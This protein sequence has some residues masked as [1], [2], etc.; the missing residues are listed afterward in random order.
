[1]TQATAV[2]H[3]VVSQKEWLAAR[4]KFLAKE[5]EHMRKG[6]ELAAELRGLPWV[7]VEKTYIFD[8]PT[9]KKSLA[10]LFD[11]RSQL[12][13]DHFMFGPGW[14][15]G[16]PGC[17]FM[18]DH[19]DGMLPHLAN[20]DV[21]YVA[22]SRAT[23]SEIE[24]FRKRMGWAIPWVSSNQNDFNYDFHVS[25]D[26]DEAEQGEVYYNYKN[27]KGAPETSTGEAPG[28]SVFF[29]D[30]DGAIFHTYSTFGRGAELAL[31]TYRFLDIVPK[32]RDEAGLPFPMAW[33]RHH[34]K[35]ETQPARPEV[36]WPEHVIAS[37][38]S[39]KAA[40]ESCCQH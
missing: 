8:T 14:E 26:M 20:R 5:K 36:S 40:K 31:G 29:K 19:I 21:S 22:V 24:A 12:I 34:D 18:S 2:S 4:Q 9:G 37:A 10:E 16:C 15:E 1:M 11:G 7:R 13:V 35:Y 28:I 39:H 17:S 25:F 32:G 30:E 38:S 3:K 33:V 6:D 23:V 27:R